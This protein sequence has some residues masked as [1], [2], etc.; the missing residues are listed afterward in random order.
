[1]MMKLLVTISLLILAGCVRTLTRNELDGL[2]R[3]QIGYTVAEWHYMGSKKGYHYFNCSGIVLWE[4]GKY[5]ILRDNLDI[6]HPFAYTTDSSR[7][8]LM[9]WAAPHPDR[10]IERLETNTDG[11]VYDMPVWIIGT[12]NAPG[13]YFRKS[14]TTP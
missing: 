11:L 5:R 6:P 1:M 12:N 2:T 10:Y 8:R 7:W 13:T 3:K 4:G 9:P 14:N